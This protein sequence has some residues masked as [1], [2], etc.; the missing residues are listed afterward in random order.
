MK[1]LR[2]L[3]DAFRLL[4]KEHSSPPRL[5]AA[6]GLGALVGSSPFF[7]LHA[8]IGLVLSR[9]FRLNLLGV[10]LG[11]QVSLPFLA[12]LLI[13]ASV[14]TGTWVLHGHGLD[15]S[16]DM[17]TVEVAG[18]FFVAW[19]LGG[20]I[21]G[22]GLGA[23]IF[24]VT[25]LVLRTV[26]ARID[27]HEPVAWTGRSRGT[28]LGYELF[29]LALRI[30]GRRA[31][32]LI[33]IPVTA[34]FFVFARKSR[35]ASQDFFLRVQGPTS[36]GQRQLDTWRHFN[37]LAQTLSDRLQ[38]MGGNN[39]AFEIRHTDFSNL[40]EALSQ[41]AGVILL[42][43]HFGSWGI[44]GSQFQ[45]D[46]PL[47]VVVYDNE[48]EGVRRF[49]QRRLKGAPPKVIVQNSG[50]TASMD[51]LRA[52]RNREVV[53]MLADRVAPGGAS[54]R[55]PFFG[56]EIELPVGP[57]QLA[58]IS[59]APIVLSFGYKSAPN[60]HELLV[61]PARTFKAQGRQDRAGVIADGARWFAEAL[62]AQVRAHPHQWFNFYP[63][64]AAPNRPVP[65]TSRHEVAA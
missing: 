36:W 47:N 19:L 18:Q 52:L 45:G 57:F 9:L 12:P 11:T 46:V 37:T 28:G 63:Y 61:L 2:R 25:L 17:I 64:W 10:T 44:A 50:P 65:S 3:Q 23:L 32:Y 42:S 1:L 15:L 40:E 29:Y 13:F 21:V 6:V 48:A 7:G 35:R 14:Q 56:A 33:L 22:S 24:C 43:A 60:R 5:S 59:G 8:A 27:E 54:V 55:V 31:A 62:E 39:E 58:L 51:I 16:L 4:A 30:L 49:F 20:L 53:A 26:R 34:W 41:D 38:I